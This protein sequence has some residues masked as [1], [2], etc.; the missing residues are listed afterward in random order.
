[1]EA[2]ARRTGRL[3][4]SQRAIAHGTGGEPG[5][6]LATRLAMPISGDTLLRLIRATPLEPPPPPRIVGIDDGAW[7]RGRRYG[8]IVVDLERH[9]P[10]DLLPDRDAET[11]AAWFRDHPGLE[12]VARDRTGADAEGARLGAPEAVPVADRWHLLRNLGD[13]L[14]RILDRRP[15]DLR[16]AAKAAVTVLRAA[17]EVLPPMLPPAS[18]PVSPQRQGVLW[19]RPGSSTGPS[20]ASSMS[21]SPVRPRASR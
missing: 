20:A 11:V 10:V 15:P 21:C 17:N 16:A 5:S 9:R 13:A 1:M 6:R 4:D 3:A 2:Q 18:R 14:P 19:P 8:T 12:I 7:H